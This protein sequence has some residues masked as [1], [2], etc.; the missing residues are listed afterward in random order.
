M[1]FKH[2]LLSAIA[3]SLLYVSGAI[4]GEAT[5]IYPPQSNYSN[6]NITYISG[7][8]GE[9]SQDALKQ[10]ESNYNL[11]VVSSFTTG[12]Y[13][14]N[15][16]VQISDKQGTVLINTVSDGPLFYA[17]LEPGTYKVTAMYGDTLKTQTITIH[18]NTTLKQVVM[19]WKP[20]EPVNS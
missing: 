5:V 13:L 18:K 4:A 2:T 12:H 1:N 16:P 11:K 8:V 20:D 3:I 9:K 19:Q 15:I 7:G 10:L 17:N 14:S 6:H